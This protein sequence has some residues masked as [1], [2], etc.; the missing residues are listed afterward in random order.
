MS[1]IIGGGGV[2]VVESVWCNDHRAHT[3]IGRILKLNT[4]AT[5]KSNLQR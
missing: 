2:S 5:L 1:L 3:Q 4:Q